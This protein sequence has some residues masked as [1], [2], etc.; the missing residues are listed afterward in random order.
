MDTDETKTDKIDNTNENGGLKIDYDP[1]KAH[2][3]VVTGIV[4]R[5]G[6]FLITKRASHEPAFPGKWTIPGGKFEADDYLQREKD[7]EAL[8]YNIFNDS[9]RREIREEVNLEI[10]KISYLTDRVYV[11]SDGI[12]TV[13]ISLFAEYHD[14]DV[15]L[16]KD[17]D[18]HAWVT[19]E[20][21]R[22]YDFIDGIYEELEMLDL[23]LK[24]GELGEW[25][26]SG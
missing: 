20:E 13:I 11:R 9:L 18:E 15:E 8:W 14:G 21:A 12:P 1:K 6:K 19:L 26:R 5:D 7:T 25:K 2:Y 16:C 17:L 23:Y 4:V 22:D 24:Q 3:L 10:K